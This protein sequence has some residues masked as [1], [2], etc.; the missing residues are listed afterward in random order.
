MNWE[1]IVKKAEY[2]NGPW[3]VEWDAETGFCVEHAEL[4]T[5]CGMADTEAGAFE[6]LLESV[7]EYENRILRIKSELK[8]H[9]DELRMRG[10]DPKNQPIEK[11]DDDGGEA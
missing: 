8:T 4:R 9:L 11:I 3:T 2:R 7:E 10:T 1:K 6:A 5:L